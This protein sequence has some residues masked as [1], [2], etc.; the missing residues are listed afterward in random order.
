MAL[1]GR[2]EQII[3]E[4]DTEL[5][6]M[7]LTQEGTEFNKDTGIL[8]LKSKDGTN[9]IDVQFNFNFGTF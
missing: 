2:N 5:E 3:I 7:M 1:K 6:G 4:K 8:T 9:N